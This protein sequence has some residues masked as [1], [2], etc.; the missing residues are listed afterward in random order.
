MSRETDENIS[1][2]PNCGACLEFA[3]GGPCTVGVD[4][5]GQYVTQ[6]CVCGLCDHEYLDLYR[7][8]RTC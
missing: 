7:F 6:E 1:R 2:C 8:E 4:S 3:E 5:Q